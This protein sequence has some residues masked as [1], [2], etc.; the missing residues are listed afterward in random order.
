MIWKY[1]IITFQNF[2]ELGRAECKSIFIPPQVHLGYD[3][4]GETPEIINM[5]ILY[6][7]AKYNY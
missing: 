2:K 6:N 3:R 4:I 5:Y 1:Y 7:S